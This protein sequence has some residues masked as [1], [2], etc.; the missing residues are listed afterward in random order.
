MLFD[1]KQQKKSL[2]LVV[3]WI[4]FQPVKRRVLRADVHPD[5]DFDR[6]HDSQC[7]R[8]PR[9]ALHSQSLR[10]PLPARAEHPKEEEK[11]Q[12]KEEEED[13]MFR[14]GPYF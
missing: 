14:C 1:L 11:L 12:G 6:V 2:R 7:I 13:G 10:H 3:I 5:G 9:D 8:F 4:P